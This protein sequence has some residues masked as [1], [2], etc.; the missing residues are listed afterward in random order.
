MNSLVQVT[1]EGKT[2]VAAKGFYW[3]DYNSICGISN[4][5]EGVKNEGIVEWIF[6]QKNCFDNF[7]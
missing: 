1:K 6:E 5:R 4:R 3:K 2:F 7:I